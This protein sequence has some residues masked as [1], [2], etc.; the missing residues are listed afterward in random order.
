MSSKKSKFAWRN[1]RLQSKI[2]ISV[3][4]TIICF[5][6]LVFGYF[7]PT[8]K[9]SLIEQKKIK[10]QDVVDTGI[11]VLEKLNKDYEEGDIS[12]EEAQA[13]AIDIIKSMKYGN[14]GKDYLWINDFR[15]F[16]IMH[17]YRTD[18]NGKDVSDYA[19]PAGK[20]LF[21][22]MAK[23]CEKSG[24][25][26][27]NYI[28]QWKDDT[29]KI[30][31][32]I[33]YV[34]SF[35]PWKWIVGTGIYIEDVNEEIAVIYKKMILIFAGISLVIGI[36]LFLVSQAISK[37]VKKILNFAKEIAS[38]NFKQRIDLK[39]EDELGKLAIALNE[40]ASHLEKD[41]GFFKNMAEPAFRTNNQLIIQS[42][43]DAALKT[44]GFKREE[45][46]GKMTCADLCRTPVCGTSSCT[47]KRCI[48]TKGSLIATT[49][50]KTRDDKI[51]PVRAACGVLLDSEGNPVGGFEMVSDLRQ[52]DDGFLNNM[53]DAAFRTDTELTIQNINDAALKAM[54]YTRDE[55]V[56]K[57]SCADF[58]KTPVCGTS[59][60]TIKRC[61]NAKTTI[62]AE[63]VATARDGRKIPV[64][65]AC[66]VLLDSKGN[67]TGGFEVISDN[68]DFA[69]MVDTTEAISNGDLTVKVAEAILNRNDAVG[70]LAQAL[71]RMITS[72]SEI[73]SGI[74]INSQTLAQAVEQ[75]SSGNQNLSQRT[76]EQASSL[77]EVA[78]TIEE[79]TATIKQNADNAGNA[80][81]M[82]DKAS[83]KAE[84]GVAIIGSAVKSINEISQSSKKIGEI[85]TMINEISFQT[86]LLAL[87]AAVEAARAGEQGR[88]FA[89]VAGEVR[90]LAQR[91]A[92][93]AKEIGTLI[94]DSIEKINTGTGLVNKSGESLKEITSSVKDVSKV[95]SEIAAASQEQRL[96]VEQVNKAVIEMDTMTQQ[97]A[98]LVEETATASE[99]MA[100][101]AQE[102]MAIMEKFTVAEIDRGRIQAKNS[103]HL[104]AN[105]SAKSVPGKKNDIKNS[106]KIIAERRKTDA[107]LSDS[108]KEEGFEEF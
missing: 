101:Q 59:E 36:I 90:N 73:I 108:M 87:N 93:A 45:V 52:L 29:Q 33:S 65:A 77:E 21:V 58:C 94:N 9:S 28:W 63:T 84:E 95:V 78:S 99:A 98:A 89:V 72:L 85:I 76:A 8:M 67:P 32:K 50:L 102:L 70:K 17:P 16:M 12:I 68:S 75:I 20:R 15:P 100:T 19:D 86:N 49:V 55:V 62:I 41:E 82:A 51:I 39:Q 60:C 103:I 7:I 71:S 25:G 35:T 54:G 27:V 14:E 107:G 44:M 42:I 66:G 1:I 43:N 22:E 91:S 10:L 53:A 97:N 79:T 2:F 37:P 106:N 13:R 40:A 56:G 104:K 92:R 105:D 57:M 48:E 24:H 46:V 69:K 31:P 18:L 6:A 4:F 88:G 81:T 5:I 83:R 34:K 23:V 96:G 74:I 61:I 3:V 11:S 47:I 26:F 80:N 30:V 38:G 64:R